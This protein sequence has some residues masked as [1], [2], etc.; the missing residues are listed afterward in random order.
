MAAAAPRGVVI[1]RI[2]SRPPGRRTRRSSPRASAPE[3]GDVADAEPD[4]RRVER[5]VG[6]RKLEQV[7]PH[8]VDPRPTSA[9]ARSSIGSEKSSPVTLLPPAREGRPAR[10]RRCRSRRRARGRPAGRPDSSRE[11]RASSGRGPR[12]SRGSSRHRPARSGRTSTRRRSPTGCRSR[13]V[14]AVPDPSGGASAFLDPEL[15]EASA[16]TTKSTRSSTGSPRG[17]SPA[18]GEHA[19]PARRSGSMSRGGSSRAASRA[20]EY[21]LA[22][23][24]ERDPRGAVDQVLHR[25][26]GD[27]PERPHRAGADHVARPP[28]PSR[29][30]TATT[31]PSGRRSSRR[32][33][34]ARGSGPASR[35]AE[36]R[37]AVQLGADHLDAARARRRRSRRPPA[38]SASSS[39]AA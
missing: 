9:R 14:A 1:S 12:S 7:A 31:S 29:S 21:E 39:R 20:G 13:A 18:R 35:R 15:V 34:A 8:P 27:R 19:A 26:R 4:G 32:A 30:R 37:I 38:A 10:G 23:L 17:R 16:P 6:E 2:A 36:A 25:A 22:P 24:L 3:V 5:A 28:S 11:P 33:P